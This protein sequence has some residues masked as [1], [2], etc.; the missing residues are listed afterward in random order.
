[1]IIN[2]DIFEEQRLKLPIPDF[3]II[4]VNNINEY[5]LLSENIDLINGSVFCSKYIEKSTTIP[6]Y[7]FI[8]KT[9]NS[10]D[11]IK[12]I[13][14]DVIIGNNDRNKGNLLV[15]L[16][17]NSLVMIDHSHVFIGEAIWDEKTL[18]E[19]I[20]N[21]ISI[22]QMNPFFINMF[23]YEVNKYDKRELERYIKLIRSIS[24][25]ELR[26]IVDEIPADWE[27]SQSE[28]NTLISFVFDRIKRVDEIC[29]ILG[30]ER[31]N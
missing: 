26:K 19:L 10:S 28:K 20:D 25:D 8:Q 2:E 21:K 14:F 30:L 4:K 6:S 11:I 18:L 5:N 17:N 15:N 13:I 3:E 22:E 27:I 24:L 12:I 9:K 1:M 7:R 16:K 31:G 23:S 29:E